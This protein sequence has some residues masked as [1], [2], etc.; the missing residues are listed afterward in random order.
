[1]KTIYK[2]NDHE[3]I[4]LDGLRYRNDF[5]RDDDLGSTHMP[6]F[7]LR[8]PDNEGRLLLKLG[9]DAVVF[10][11][12][13]TVFGFRYYDDEGGLSPFR[14]AVIGDLK[15]AGKVAV[16]ARYSQSADSDAFD[17][18]QPFQDLPAG[19]WDLRHE[20]P[21]I[22]YE[23]G[24]DLHLDRAFYP[25]LRRVSFFHGGRNPDG[26]EEYSISISGERRL[27]PAGRQDSGSRTQGM[28]H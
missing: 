20:C 28:P 22:F 11:P 3:I 23:S 14:T 4:S 5:T 24:W 21:R 18:I 17:R 15:G 26:V 25:E 8:E 10:T 1:M 2:A 13:K 19:R 16:L 27:I 6:R 9:E 7:D 12:E